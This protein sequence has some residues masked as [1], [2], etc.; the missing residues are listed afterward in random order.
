MG[1][2]AGLPFPSPADLPDLGI[3]PESPE[4]KA[5]FLPSEPPGKLISIKPL[6]IKC[7]RNTHIK[8]K[9]AVFEYNTKISVIHS[10]GDKLN[11]YA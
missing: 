9:F 11:R 10:I 4:L 1:G 7:A 2:G 8:G 5:D 3:Y 6:K